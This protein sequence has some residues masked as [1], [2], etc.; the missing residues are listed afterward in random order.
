MADRFSQHDFDA[1]GW[2][3]A[4][5]NQCAVRVEA[6]RNYTAVVEDEKVAGAQMLSNIREKIIAEIA[7]CTVHDQHAARAALGGRLLRDQILGQVVVEI[8]DA[9]LRTLIL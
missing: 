1:A 4:I 6:R 2:F 7:R 8:F 3:F 9:V 5:A